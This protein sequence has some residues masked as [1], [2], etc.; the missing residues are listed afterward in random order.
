M[1]RLLTLFILLVIQSSLYGEIPDKKEEFIYSMETFNGSGFSATFCREDSDTVYILADSENFF[2]ARKTLL[3]Y[4]P[5]KKEW[6]IDK[7]LFK[8]F[9]GFLQVIDPDGKI[10]TQ[11]NVTFTYSAE[12]SDYGVKWQV[13]IEDEALA[14]GT[15]FENL[16]NAN[17]KK[18]ELYQKESQLYEQWINL[19]LDQIKKER[20]LGNST[21]HLV[22]Q[23]ESLEKPV[24]PETP[25]LMVNPLR[26]AHMVKLPEGEYKIRFL[27]N[28]G[29]VMEGSEKKLVVFS[30]RRTNGIGYDIVPENR[31]T[32]PVKSFTPSSI[33]YVN[34]TTDLYL[35]PFFEDEYN[36][37]FYNKMLINQ[38]K[39]N[40]SLY[41]WEEVI[42]VPKTKME[43][44]DDKGTGRM[45]T[46]KSYMAEQ[47]PGASLGYKIVLHDPEGAHKNKPPSLKGYHIPIDRT[48]K[49][50]KVRL[51]DEAGEYNKLSTRQI[52]IKPENNYDL[53][54]MI[55]S[56]LPLL[57]MLFVTYLR[58][59]Y[60][61]TV[62]QSETK[63]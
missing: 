29:L 44:T 38:S 3:Y 19:F 30:K 7:T 32:K 34:G 45:V 22:K 20:A 35:K 50:L 55:L 14:K 53:I 5:L 59:N 18:Q 62:V 51:Q 60:L 61:K 42:Q 43:I 9:E 21:D 24:A 6:T 25:G 1:R 37:L 23:I 11:P 54:L 28:D 16:I 48:N 56:A 27:N 58:N 17:K 41:R 12:E 57:I 33:L 10:N 46:E 36:D 2:W 4:W 15:E 8:T 39:G 63:Q 31:W 40:P 52:N 49:Y 26:T 47:V 13:F